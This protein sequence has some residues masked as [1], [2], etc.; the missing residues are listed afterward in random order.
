MLPLDITAQ[1]TYPTLAPDDGAF[2]GG[3]A[4]SFTAKAGNAVEVWG[5]CTVGAGVL[6][7]LFWDGAAWFPLG[8]GKTI[9]AA[10]APGGRFQDAWWVG[11]TGG[12][13]CCVYIS[14]GPTVTPLR[15][16]GARL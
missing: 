13:K 14:G 6:Y 7:L 11:D 4:G 9:D 16:A 1:T 2:V 15:I 3:A 5:T 12:R 8:S 10:A